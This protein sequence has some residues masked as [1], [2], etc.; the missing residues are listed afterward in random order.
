MIDQT[1]LQEL[2]NRSPLLASTPADM[3]Y[4]SN[5]HNRANLEMAFPGVGTF[6]YLNKAEEDRSKKEYKE[7]SYE[8]NDMGFR[9]KYPNQDTK[10]ILGFFGCSITFGEGLP[11]ED[12]FPYHLGNYYNSPILNLG[13]CGAGARRIALIF[14]AATRIWDIETAVI[15]LPD[16]GRFNYVDRE[17]NLLSIL[18][19]HR[20]GSEECEKVRN[21]LIK[22]FSDQF[23]MSETK[24]AIS[25]IVSIA[26]EKNI[27]L[28][29]GSWELGTREITKAIL[30]YEAAPFIYQVSVETARD[31]VHPGPI[32]CS[33]YTE[34]IKHYIDNKKYV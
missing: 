15:T 22:H 33:N 8:I 5:L 10:N 34:T 20:H 14:Q 30:N 13:M 7:F 9:G 3:L 23:L 25:F 2:S 19:P 21:S 18:P 12:N 6:K 29:L 16:W 31:N 1:I 4:Y 17:N 27:K 32:A 28:I 24:D 11:E 26:K